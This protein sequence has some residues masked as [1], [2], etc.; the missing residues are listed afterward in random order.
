MAQYSATKGY[1]INLAEA[2]HWEG[3]AEGVDVSVLCP[4][5]T[6]TPAKDH[7]DVDYDQL[8]IKWME[9]DKVVRAGLD[10]L[11]KRPII[12]PGLRNHLF[13]CIGSGLYT[14]KH[15]QRFMKIL[16]AKIQKNRK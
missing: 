1:L 6:D 14:R 15:A 7:F 3:K 12:I 8:P 10:S 9:V 4:G 16:Y 11:G 13:S 5:A 2:L